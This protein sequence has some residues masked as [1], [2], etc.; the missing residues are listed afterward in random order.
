VKRLA[1]LL[2]LSVAFAPLAAQA[3]DIDLQRL[4]EDIRILSSDE[5]EGRGPATPAEKKTVDYI[6]AQMKAAGL[7]PGGANGG[8]TQTV[9][10]N[11]FKLAPDAGATVK[12]G[13]WNRSL[14][15]GIDIALRTRLPQQRLTLKDAPVV[16]VGYGVNAPERNWNDFKG[17]DLRGKVAIVLVNDPDFELDQPGK[18]EGERMTYYGRWTY[19]FEELARQGA[20][21][22]LVV[23][24]TVPIGYGWATVRNSNTNGVFDIVL[25]DAAKQRT[26]LEGF[27]QKPVAEELFKRA[28]LD[29]A[30]EKERAKTEAFTPVTLKGAAFSM[31][32]AVEVTRTQ[33][34][35]VLGRLPGSKRPGETVLIGAHWDHLGRA[36]ADAD[37]DDIYNG[38]LDNATGV[39]GLLELARVMAAGPKPERSVVFAAW[40]VE[41]RGLL[42]SEF[43]AQNPVHPLA[44][45][46][47]VFNMDG[48]AVD[49]PA[50]DVSFIGGGKSALD[51]RAAAIAQGMGL[52][53]SPDADPG[54]GYY[55]R[56]DHFPLAKVGVPAIYIS[57]GQ[58]LVNGGVEAGKAKDEAY[59]ADKYHQ[60]NDEFDPNWDLSG[61]LPELNII[62]TLA[63]EV[64]NSPA[65]PEWNPGGEF[66]PARQ[67]TAAQR[68]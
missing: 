35:N 62:R 17:L 6:I 21:G 46:A 50:R 19:K 33:S 63:T 4:R 64:A 48:L 61:A 32:T 65:W 39:G 20:A 55:F 54:A 51:T 5:F 29:F 8:W 28:G 38:A 40:T 12:V 10:L 1:A 66:A 58:D 31:D 18:F 25:E 59:R 53:V 2:S 37:G 7:Q 23:H 24:E 56:S 47:A 30:A 16:F 43:Y 45:T 34:D 13:D 44:T 52:K 49:G 22:V 14:A 41:E 67:Q 11:L 26:A 15:Q 9:G 68:R 3:A 42:G 36:G 57:N 27:I 60:P